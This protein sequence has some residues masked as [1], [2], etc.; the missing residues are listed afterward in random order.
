MFGQWS[1]SEKDSQCTPR[2]D[3]FFTLGVTDES[4]G[5]LPRT[6]LSTSPSLSSSSSDPATSS[7]WP[8]FELE[9]IEFALCATGMDVGKPSDFVVGELVWGI[10]ASA[11]LSA[12]AS[13]LEV[14]GSTPSCHL[15]IAVMRFFRPR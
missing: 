10:L 4:E 15:R 5:L 14:M 1:I 6:M 12:S 2:L 3:A 7:A 13:S 11:S 9:A 8:T